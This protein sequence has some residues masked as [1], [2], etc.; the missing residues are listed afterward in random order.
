V[1]RDARMLRSTPDNLSP[2]DG[3][4][5]TAIVGDVHGCGEALAR[6][7]ERLDSAAPTAR[8]ILV[9]DLLTKGPEPE[10]VVELLR[11]R[12]AAGRPAEAV[13]GNHDRRMLAALIG[14]ERGLPTYELPSAERRCFEALD[15]ADRLA[16]AKALLET[17]VQQV[18]IRD[19]RGFTVLHAGIDPSL[20]LD[21]TPDEVK[22]SIRSRDG[23]RPWWEA[24]HGEDGLLVFGHKPQERPLRRYARG[25]LAA[26]NVD[27]GCVGGGDLTAYL[28][29]TD[30]FVAVRGRVAS[31]RLRARA[32]RAATLRRAASD[33]RDQTRVGST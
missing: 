15:R 7:L 31:P 13:C 16:D 14:V 20:G 10:R 21:R 29:E 4:F 26:V 33:A 27:T 3:R 11:S 9:G 19:P 1:D 17:T 30:R 28:V 32:D 2:P 23:E 8:V 12:A 25:R 22:W 5:E 24:Y 18:E 6:L